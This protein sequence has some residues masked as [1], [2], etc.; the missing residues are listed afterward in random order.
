MKSEYVFAAAFEWGLRIDV[1]ISYFNI[2]KLV[3][4]VMES[5][6]YYWIIDIF[7]Y[8]LFSTFINDFWRISYLFEIF[9]VA[10]LGFV[11]R[12]GWTTDILY[13]IVLVMVG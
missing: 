3:R 6:W 10:V 4:F 2:V 13:M 8:T 1:L 11:K 7:E 12:L 9:Y 5:F